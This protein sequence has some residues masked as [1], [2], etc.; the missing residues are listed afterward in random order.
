MIRLQACFLAD[1]AITNADG[2]FMVWRGGIQR[3]MALALPTLVHYALVLR[4]QL[5]EESA[6]ELH[7]IGLRIMFDGTEVGPMQTA[8]VAVGV[9]T[10]GDEFSYFTM[11]ADLRIGVDRL[12]T[13]EIQIFVDEDIGG[14]R[15]PFS[16]VQYDP[17][18]APPIDPA[19]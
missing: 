5:D 13:G 11:L 10:A 16:V 15:L 8:P 7:S 12:G 4:L 18:Q 9:P 19:I 14:P 3:T 1:R 17:G 6:R 2:T